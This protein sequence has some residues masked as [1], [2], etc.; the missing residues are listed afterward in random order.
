MSVS[1]IRFSGL[2]HAARAGIQHRHPEVR[3]QA[4]PAAR[5]TRFNGKTQDVGRPARPGASG[6]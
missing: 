6:A 1:L 3:S 2:V 5:Y 4:M